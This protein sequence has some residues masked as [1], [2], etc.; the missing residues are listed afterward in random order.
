MNNPR[1]YIGSVHRE[2]GDDLNNGIDETIERKI[3][4]V[5]VLFGYRVKI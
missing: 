3:P 1:I 2:E 5:P 4:R